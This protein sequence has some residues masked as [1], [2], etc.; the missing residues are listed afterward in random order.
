MVQDKHLQHMR[1]PDTPTAR[2]TAPSIHLDDF[3][4]LYLRR[5]LLEHARYDRS[6]LAEAYAQYLD[7]QI[8]DNKKEHCDVYAHTQEAVDTLLTALGRTSM[9]YSCV[10]DHLRLLVLEAE[11]DL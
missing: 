7:T 2:E 1:Q 11:T 5:A 6:E 3:E 8:R 9:G 10:V 4:A